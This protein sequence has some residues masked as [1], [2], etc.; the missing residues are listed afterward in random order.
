MISPGVRGAGGAAAL[1]GAGRAAR[2]LGRP[3]RAATAAGALS[4]AAD[5]F[6][7]ASA[8]LNIGA[9]CEPDC[10]N[11]TLTRMA[12][13]ATAATMTPTASLALHPSARNSAR[14]RSSRSA[15]PSPRLCGHCDY[16][17]FTLR[18]ASGPLWP[19]MSRPPASTGGD[20]GA[21]TRSPSAALA[22]DGCT[23]VPIW[24]RIGAN[25]PTFVCTPDGWDAP[26]L[27]APA[28]VSEGA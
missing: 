6:R 18:T 9:G 19:T 27:L 10:M 7:R 8:P 21:V 23:H 24:S 1:A 20:G 16:A 12:T 11:S 14:P 28:M 17:L 15:P 4:V 3:R 22:T 2:R 25:R 13:V 26:P 5:R